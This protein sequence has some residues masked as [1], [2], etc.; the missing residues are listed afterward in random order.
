MGR[1]MSGSSF[2]PGPEK[3]PV[4]AVETR[5]DRDI[6]Y[7]T[8]LLLPLLC[9]QERT[10]KGQAAVA[11]RDA[12]ARSRARATP[13]PQ[14]ELSASTH[15]LSTCHIHEHMSRHP[16]THAYKHSCAHVHLNSNTYTNM[17]I[18]K[19]TCTL[20]PQVHTCISTS[21]HPYTLTCSCRHICTCVSP[22]LCIQNACTHSHAHSY[23]MHI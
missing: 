15:L 1:V 9:S 5:K 7:G 3:G 14:A 13:P 22:L 8:W 20:I 12:T 2:P 16:S 4:C 11:V 18:C 19:Y 23:S 17:C 6:N 21:M 10:A